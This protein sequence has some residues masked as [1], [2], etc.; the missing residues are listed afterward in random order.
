MSLDTRNR[1]LYIE[2]EENGCICIQ[3]AS[4]FVLSGSVVYE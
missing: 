1:V 3:N 4:K 2:A